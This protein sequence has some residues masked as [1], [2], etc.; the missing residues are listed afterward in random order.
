MSILGFD[1]EWLRERSGLA[2]AREIAQQPTTLRATAALVAAER[3]TLDAFLQPLLA[4]PELRVVLTGAGTSAFIGQCLAPWLSPRLRCHVEAVA[5]TDITCAPHLYLDPDR[6]TLL[7]SFAR[8]GDSPESVAAVD[9]VENIVSECHHLVIT[10]NADG[11]LAGRMQS[12]ASGYIL[13][14]PEVTHDRGFAMT[15]SFTAMTLAAWGLLGGGAEMSSAAERIATSVEH[16]LDAVRPQ[17]AGL[18][19]RGIDRVVY[20]GSHVLKGVACEAALKLLELTDGGVMAMHDTP[21]GFRHGPK[22]FVTPDTLAVLFL[23]ND[24]H[25]RRYDL[26]LARELV[27][28]GRARRVLLVD[29]QSNDIDGAIGIRLSGMEMS[30]DVELLFADI[31]IA[32]ILAFDMSLAQGLT[33]DQP[34]RSGTVN[35]VVQGVRIHAAA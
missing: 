27:A 12:V 16:V 34:S 7:V 17:L 3:E 15:S 11:K 35:R 1:E 8:S 5:T 29:A 31:L 28:D 23:S 9:L 22:T 6:P 30:A 24:P 26:D 21:L 10:C 19:D 20:L 13:C 25:S 33:P 4:R 32:Q 18:A 14:L 2:T